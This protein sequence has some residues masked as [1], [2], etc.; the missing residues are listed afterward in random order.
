MKHGFLEKASAAAAGNVQRWRERFGLRPEPAVAGRPVFL[1]EAAGLC[2]V[3]A[4]VKMASPS[5]GDLMGA[6]DPLKLPPLYESAGAGAVSVVVEECYFGGSPELFADIRTRTS[7]PMLWK[8]FVVDRYQLTLASALGASAVL[9]LAGMLR[10]GELADFT[11]EAREIGLRSLVEVHDA[12]ELDRA[13]A[14]GA[15][16]VGVN[17]R[18]LVSLEVDLGVSEA[19]AGR[20]SA[21]VQAV[22]ESGVRDPSTVARMRGLG[23]RAVL[24]GEALVAAPEPSRLLHAMSRA[25]SAS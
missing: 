1:P 18:D 4:E 7:L 11:A 3:I 17:N 14:L 25:G 8:D 12:G 20:F 10:D 9:L 16:L 6:R 15:D 5:R 2:S 22:C 24:V 13:L 21:G 19:L 23:Y